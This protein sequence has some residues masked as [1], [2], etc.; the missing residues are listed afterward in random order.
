MIL[1]YGLVYPKLPTIISLW[2]FRTSVSYFG[3]YG[4]VYP[5]LPTIISLWFFRTPLP[6]KLHMGYSDWT[7]PSLKIPYGLAPS[8]STIWEIRTGLHAL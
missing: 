1:P 7:L 2:F 6:I 3:R 8:K 5:K 4:L